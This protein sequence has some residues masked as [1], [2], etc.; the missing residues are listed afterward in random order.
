MLPQGIR[1]TLLMLHARA[2]CSDRAD[3]VLELAGAVGVHRSYALC[4]T[5]HALELFLLLGR[6]AGVALLQPLRE[7]TLLRLSFGLF[8]AETLRVLLE[9]LVAPSLAVGVLLQVFVSLLEESKLA[10]ACDELGV[11]AVQPGAST[12]E[13]AFRLRRCQMR[14]CT[15]LFAR[16][17][18][19]CDGLCCCPDL[20]TLALDAGLRGFRLL[21][22]PRNA[23]QPEKEELALHVP[24]ASFQAPVLVGLLLLMR[25]TLLLVDG[26]SLLREEV[27][28]IVFNLALF[29][30]QTFVLLPEGLGPRDLLKERRELLA[31]PVRDR[32]DVA[33]EDKK[34]ADLGEDVD[35]LQPALVISLRNC[36][37]VDLEPCLSSAENG[38]AENEH[39]RAL[40]RSAARGALAFGRLGMIRELDHG[41]ALVAFRILAF[42]SVNEIPELLAAQH[43]RLHAQDEA[44]CVHEVRLARAVRTDDAREMPERADQDATFIGLEVLNDHLVDAAH[45]CKDDQSRRRANG[46][47][48]ESSGARWGKPTLAIHEA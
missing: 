11:Q 46:E 24:A 43:T 40:R 39:G 45:P 28:D 3:L 38:T 44:D 22:L 33:L 47:T 9:F 18:L 14:L 12:G 17:E 31:L 6:E 10:L 20:L 35:A 5:L 21:L 30:R 37:V 42:L 7:V 26:V 27:A 36:L 15:L 4:V 13:R 8:L 48:S 19:L 32:L 29:R 41:G 23:M 1:L 34:I 2:L 16:L 25:D